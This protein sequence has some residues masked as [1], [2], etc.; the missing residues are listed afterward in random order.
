M[1]AKERG[2]LGGIWAVADVNLGTVVEIVEWV[3]ISSVHGRLT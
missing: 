3:E 2:R 1:V